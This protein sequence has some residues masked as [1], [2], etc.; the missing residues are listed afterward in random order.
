MLNDTSLLIPFISNHLLNASYN[1]KK[2]TALDKA[3]V[4][5]I[6][7]ASYTIK[8]SRDGQVTVH[9]VKCLGQ[10]K[11]TNGVL[12]G[13]DGVLI[14]PPVSSSADGTLV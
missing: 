9:G 7:N 6:T 14:P 12:H 4:S 5:A 13:I 11:G 2:L 8:L 3:F 10:H 1:T